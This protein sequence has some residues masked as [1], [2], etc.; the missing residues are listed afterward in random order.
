MEIIKDSRVI[1]WELW[2][3]KYK[4]L[5]V[6]ETTREVKTTHGS[7]PPSEFSWLLDRDPRRD[8]G[9]IVIEGYTNAMGGFGF[10]NGY[11]SINGQ[12]DYIRALELHIKPVAALETREGA[13]INATIEN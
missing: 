12:I 9:G 2:D 3:P 11:I 7:M 8:G 5:L 13:S 10:G 1:D 6:M 4:F